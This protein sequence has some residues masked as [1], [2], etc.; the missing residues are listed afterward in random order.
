MVQLQHL[1]NEPSGQM[2]TY[3]LSLSVHLQ[4]MGVTAAPG[5]P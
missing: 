5:L 4:K 2:D 1:L 3:P